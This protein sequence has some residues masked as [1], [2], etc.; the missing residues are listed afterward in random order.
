[1]TI[2]VITLFAIAAGAFF[3]TS[4]GDVS[5]LKSITEKDTV[6]ISVD[7]SFLKT[8]QSASAIS[9]DESIFTKTSFRTLENFNFQIG[10]INNP[11][12]V[13]PFA[14]IGYEQSGIPVNRRSN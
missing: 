3:Y 2:I 1:M 12:R 4:G 6:S 14:P 5:Q 9:L 13:N 7:R 10:N 8:L 11:G